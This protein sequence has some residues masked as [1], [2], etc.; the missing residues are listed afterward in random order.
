MERSIIDKNLFDEYKNILQIDILL[1]DK[2][3]FKEWNG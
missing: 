1:E 3:N 2:S